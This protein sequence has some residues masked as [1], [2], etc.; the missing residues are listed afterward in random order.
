VPAYDWRLP[1]GF[2]PPLV[3]PDNPMSPA[4][5]ALGKQLFFDRHLSVN[6]TYSCGD[7]HQPALAFTDGGA[8]PIGATGE[9]VRRS[10]MSLANAAYNPAFT[11]GDPRIKTLEAQMHTPLFKQHPVEMGMKPDDRALSAALIHDAG[12]ASGFAAAFPLDTAPVSWGNAIKAIAAFER[13]LISG[14]SSFDK[15]VFSDDTNAM[16]EPAKRGMKLFFS[17]RIGCS[18]CHSGIN[19]SGPIL[20]R[21]QEKAVAIFANNGLQGPGAR[22]KNPQRDQG[23]MEITHRPQ[24]TGKFRVPTLRNIALTAPYMHDGSLQSLDEVLDHYS[25]G[26]RHGP[27]QDSRVRRT[28]LS[29]VERRQMREFLDALTDR[30]F[31]QDP[32]FRP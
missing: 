5:V 22:D 21:G 4:K 16:S 18:Q 25:R 14:R 26:G 30:D 31:V 29:A 10:A 23:L 6:S 12:Y 32:R 1:P 24:D 19:F 7:C 20:Y 17:P 3:P 15:Y 9:S 2:P 11:W 27:F 28:P 8:H 13:T